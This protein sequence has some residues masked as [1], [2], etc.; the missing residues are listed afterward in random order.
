MD[1]SGLYY[2]G[3]RYY[4][5]QHGRWIS[6]DPLEEEGGVNLYGMVNNNV[7]SSF[8]ILG[9]VNNVFGY[10]PAEWRQS[11]FDQIAKQFAHKSKLLTATELIARHDPSHPK[12]ENCTGCDVK[13]DNCVY[14]SFY[15]SQVFWTQTEENNN[16]SHVAV[17]LKSPNVTTFPNPIGFSPNSLPVVTGHYHEETRT[18]VV[19]IVRCCCFSDEE[20]TD[21]R[22]LINDKIE[23]QPDKWYIN[24]PN[25]ATF[26]YDL[27][28]GRGD[29]NIGNIQWRS[30]VFS[31]V[32]SLPGILPRPT[33]Y[34]IHETPRPETFR[35]ALLSSDSCSTIYKAVDW[36][37]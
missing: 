9:L 7:I 11:T 23:N 24:G 20:I 8:D 10:T 35:K 36:I 14:F 2:Y 12:P 28:Q 37:E 29:A 6:H 21:I 5:P 17:W 18:D 33:S 26:A 27:I 34:I 19:A 3:Y 31:T 32:S 25:C 30:I 22:N 13:P 15:N 1:G 16:V 4:D